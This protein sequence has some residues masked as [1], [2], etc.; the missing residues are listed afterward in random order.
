[1]SYAKHNRILLVAP[2]RGLGYP[3]LFKKVFYVPNLAIRTL[4]SLTPP[5]YEVS[6]LDEALDRPDLGHYEATDADLVGLSV[7]T[8]NASRAY[9]IARALK[10]KGKTVVM[11]G[12]HVTALPSEAL[13]YSDAV[14]IGEA[15]GV[16]QE[17]VHDYATDNLQQI[18]R[19]ARPSPELAT[20]TRIS[21]A[22]HQ[23]LISV[24]PVQI[25]RGCPFG[26]EFCSVSAFYGHV[27]RYKSVEAVV[28]EIT[29][30]QSTY[31]FFV[32]DNLFASKPYA[33]ELLH[34][35][36]ALKIRWVSQAP[37]SIAWDPEILSL[38]KSSGCRGLMIGFDSVNQG[39]LASVSKRQNQVQSYK[40]AVTSIQNIGIP[41]AG[42]FIFGFDQ[43]DESV[44]EETVRTAKNLEIDLAYFFILTPYPGTQLYQTLAREDRIF[45]RDWA[46]FDCNHVVFSPRRMTP[47]QLQQGFEWA[48]K[49]F[50]SPISTLHRMFKTPAATTALANAFYMF[51]RRFHKMGSSSLPAEFSFGTNEST[52]EGGAKWKDH[53][54]TPSQMPH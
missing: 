21:P 52:T 41:I 43:D 26:C 38:A 33:R 20:P 49:E 51:G 47:A 22:S 2:T 48:W 36:H 40:G 35:L 31:V 27:T 23:S 39:S 14:V 15:E 3:R 9:A 37:I 13:Q 42:S 32:D 53:H 46:K 18:Y 44:F 7:S 4:A 8:Q 28:N 11:G 17:L 25:S 12:I 16:W 19:A 45:E 50:Y 1:M 34:R 30:A 24:R 29:N 6:L 54:Q 5:D 10:R